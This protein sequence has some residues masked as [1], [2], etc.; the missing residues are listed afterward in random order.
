MSP[1]FSQEKKPLPLKT[2]EDQPDPHEGDK[3]IFVR[4]KSGEI[5]KMKLA[6]ESQ[7]DVEGRRVGYMVEDDEDDGNE[8]IFAHK[9]LSENTLSAEKQN[10]LATEFH[11]IQEMADA[12]EAAYRLTEETQP[13]ITPD[14]QAEIETSAELHEEAA[15]NMGELATGKSAAL[16]ED[17]ETEAEA[18]PESSD[19]LQNKLAGA[20]HEYERRVGNIL[21]DT[22][23]RTQG[24]LDKLAG[25]TRESQAQ[26]NSALRNVSEGVA[27]LRQLAARMEGGDDPVY[28]R[29][30]LN[31]LSDVL[32]SSYSQMNSGVESTS[33]S[34]RASRGI[35]SD[36]EESAK[37]L[38]MQDH[39]AHEHVAGELAQKEPGIEVTVPEFSTQSEVAQLDKTKEDLEG[40]VTDLRRVEGSATESVA[41]LRRTIGVVDGMSHDALNG[42][43]DTSELHRLVAQLTNVLE[44]NQAVRILGSMDEKFGDMKNKVTKLG[45]R[46]Q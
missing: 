19:E 36:F 31:N 30:A 6:D 43:F 1:E 29:S 33:D 24:M 17:P 46:G 4:R 7:L 15:E 13:I 20:K 27:M 45:T 3:D 21:D 28:A 12:A 32:H 23:N 25:N 10:E 41:L 39:I 22:M 42:R 18:S 34:I 8:Y 16:E 2:R 37:E 38:S 40:V 44:A 11:A 5:V 35:F 26:I 9:P 14:T